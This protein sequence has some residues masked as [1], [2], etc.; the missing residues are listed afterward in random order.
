MYL[1]L[2]KSVKEPKS[3]ITWVYKKKNMVFNLG[4]RA[5][6]GPG[7]TF[8]WHLSGQRVR[9]MPSA[10]N[11]PSSGS[12]LTTTVLPFMEVN[13]DSPDTESSILCDN[14]T[15]VVSFFRTEKLS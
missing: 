14:A 7:S 9:V 13:C 6:Q 8:R 10:E 3:F 12:F 15:C 2:F 5:S 11:V 4:M 1:G